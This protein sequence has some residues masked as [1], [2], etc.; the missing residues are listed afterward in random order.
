MPSDAT[1]ARVATAIRLPKH[2]HEALRLHAE[3]RDV[4]VNFLIVR[5]VNDFL[6]QLPT[7]EQLQASLRA[8]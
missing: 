8:S 4:S 3:A 1:D 6:E 5:A 2:L 7:P